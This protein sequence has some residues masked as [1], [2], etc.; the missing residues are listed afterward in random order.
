[1]NSEPL[2][3]STA[4]AG[5]SQTGEIGMTSS[6]TTPVATTGQAALPMSA[7]GQEEFAAELDKA[8]VAK[9]SSGPRDKAIQVLGLVLAIAGIAVA[10]LCY[11]QA[12]GFSDLRDQVQVG[13]LAIA[14]LG[15]V[16]LGTGLYVASALS[17]FLRLWLLRLVYEQRERGPR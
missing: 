11:T 5:A 16:V 1:M 6:T 8:H 3:T 15:M 14:G 7:K 10:V 13:I 9:Q 4:S 17:R 12:T 2:S